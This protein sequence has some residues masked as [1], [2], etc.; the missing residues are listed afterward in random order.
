[1]QFYAVLGGVIE[2]VN[3]AIGKS[4]AVI[5][6]SKACKMKSSLECGTGKKKEKIVDDVYWT[7][8]KMCVCVCVSIDCTHL[9]R[10]FSLLLPPSSSAKSSHIFARVDVIIL[11]NIYGC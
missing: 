5:R 6:H 10:I 9:P 8:R 4:Y 7:W 1:M 3:V 2:E 11:G